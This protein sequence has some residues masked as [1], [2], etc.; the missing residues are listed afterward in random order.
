[1]AFGDSTKPVDQMTAEELRKELGLDSE[2]GEEVNVKVAPQ[3]RT[4]GVPRTYRAPDRGQRREPVSPEFGDAFPGFD[5]YA[6][7]IAPRYSEADLEWLNGLSPEYLTQIQYGLKNA[8]LIKNFNKG[9]WTEDEEDA[10]ARVFA[11]ANRQGL[12]WEDALTEFA[13]IADEVRG[14]GGGGGG[15]RAAFTAR[16]SNPD[17]LKKAF[18]QSL[19]DA[20]GGVFM[21]DAAVQRMVDAYQQVEY[22]AQRAAYDGGADI[23]EP[24]TAQTFAAEEAKKADP[25]G[26]GAAKFA[27][28]GQIFEELIGGG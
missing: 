25:G 10:M 12:L 27:D 6:T 2:G 18:K 13:S 19:Y 23:V 3:P 15:G 7:G 5:P 21:D 24:P 4:L 17:D 26:V 22:G 28:Y 9:E 16:L 8:G 20:Q 11:Y 1:M 14:S